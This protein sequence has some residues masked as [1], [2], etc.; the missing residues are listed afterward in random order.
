MML[1]QEGRRAKLG[2]SSINLI[3][4]AIIGFSLRSGFRTY[5]GLPSPVT[6]SVSPDYWQLAAILVEDTAYNHSNI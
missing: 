3:N 5:S 1:K 2:G 6:S 4:N